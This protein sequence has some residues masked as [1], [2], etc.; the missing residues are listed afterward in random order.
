MSLPFFSALRII[1]PSNRE[2]WTSRAVVFLGPQNDA[3][4]EG[5][6][7]LGWDGL[8]GFVGINANS[9]PGLKKTL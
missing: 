5:S 4:F 2:V 1:G 9:L 3:T 7:F 8:F 6:G